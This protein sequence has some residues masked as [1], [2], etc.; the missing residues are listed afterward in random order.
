M[1]FS[2]CKLA[3]VELPPSVEEVEER[4]FYDSQLSE[5]TFC[6]GNRLRVVRDYA[7]G[8]NEQL[9]REEVH[10]PGSTQISERAF[11]SV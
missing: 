5:V 9:K 11:D 7:F 10:F 2:G 6:G 1:C 8:K 3:S 4:A